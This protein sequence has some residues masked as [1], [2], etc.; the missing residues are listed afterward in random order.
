MRKYCQLGQYKGHEVTQG[1]DHSDC[2][3]INAKGYQ[4]DYKPISALVEQSVQFGNC[5]NWVAEY[6]SLG[7][8]KMKPK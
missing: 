7:T 3:I 8:Q 2:A 5:H 6:L 1:M 4:M